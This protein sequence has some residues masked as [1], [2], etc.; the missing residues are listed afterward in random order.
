EINLTADWAVEQLVLTVPPGGGNGDLVPRSLR[1]RYA[2]G[3]LTLEEIRASNPWPYPPREAELTETGRIAAE[4]FDT[5]S[6]ADNP[7]FSCK[8]TSVIFDWVFDWP[9]NRIVQRF[10]AYGNRVIDISYGLYG[11]SRRIHV[12][13]DAHPADLE[14][15]YAG[16]SIG[17]WEGDTLVVDT[18]GF[19]AGVLVAPIRNSE[20]MRIVE[21]FTL[22]PDAQQIRRAYTVTDPVYLAQPYTGEDVVLLSQTPF[23]YHPCEELTWEYST[24]ATED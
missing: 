12:G 13:M 23:E 8:P 21:R 15:G 24:G 2:S 14:P 18:I 4:R 9:I 11:L 22:A 19:E 6:A 5:R 7:R 17:R 16:H 20:Q 10:D 1:E 3:E